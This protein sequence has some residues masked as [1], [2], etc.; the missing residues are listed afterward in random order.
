V[1]QNGHLSLWQD[2]SGLGNN[3]FQTNVSFQPTLSQNSISGLPAVHFSGGQRMSLPGFMNGASA[4]EMFVVLRIDPYTSG[5]IRG[6]M[7]IGSDVNNAHYPIT[8]GVIADNFGST[9]RKDAAGTPEQDLSQYHIYNAVSGSAEWTS[10]INTKLFYTTSSNVVG[11]STSPQIG[12][13]QSYYFAGDMAEILVYNRQLSDLERDAVVAYLASRYPD[14]A[15]LP[16]VPTGLRAVSVSATQASVTWTFPL[17]TNAP[18]EFNLERKTAQ[19]NYV[20]VASLT[21]ATSYF[22]AG[23]D[24]NEIYTYRV[25]AINFT[26]ISGFSTEATEV[27][28]PA[29]TEAEMPFDGIRV[30]LKADASGAN[31]IREW[32]DQTG[33]G[34]DAIQYVGSKQPLYVAASLDGRPGIHF[35]GGQFVI[36][37]NFMQGALAGE[38]FAVVRADPYTTGTIRGFM[39]IGSNVDNAHYP[40][41]GGVIADNFGSTARKDGA[42]APVQDLSQ[43][44]LYDAVSA[45]NDWKSRINGMLYYAVNSNTVGFSTTPQIGLSQS[46]YFAGDLAE[47]LIYDHVLTEEERLA[48]GHY[49]AGKYPDLAGPAPARPEDFVADLVSS[50]Q[51]YLGWSYTL[52]NY[53]TT[54]VV[55]KSESGGPF[56]EVARVRNQ[57]SFLDGGLQPDTEYSYRVHALNEGGESDYSDPASILAKGDAGPEVPLSN[58]RLWLAA[59]SITTNPVR[60]WVSSGSVGTDVLALQVDPTHRP[61]LVADALHGR[62]SVHFDGTKSLSLPGFM[63]G[64]TGGEMFVVLRCDPY[65]SGTIR[66]FMRVGSDGN[67]AHYPISGEIADSFGS[68]IRQDG[69]GIVLQDLSQ[70]HIYNAVSVPGGWTNRI[71]GILNYT[72]AVNTVG[73][74]N[75]P[76]IGLSQGYYFA[77]DIAEMIVYDRGLNADEEAAVQK[78]LSVKYTILDPDND[79]LEGDEELAIGT[80]P[81]N[82]DSNDNGLADGPEYFAGYDPTNQDTDGDGVSNSEEL[83]LGTDPFLADTDHDGV[84]DGDDAFPVDPTRWDPPGSGDPN[85]HTPPTITLVEPAGATLLP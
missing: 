49:L 1:D 33:N 53:N 46:Y 12:C 31:F 67:N 81:N 29:Q 5:T 52:P 80:D 23:L 42:G 65:T 50:T 85:D 27:Y 48:V 51:A 14:I 16:S 3:A 39:R 57:T 26:G 4:G 24:P 54:F 7:R 45:P 17:T 20:T 37:P 34:E 38:M 6:F 74:S 10:R 83:T 9:V 40:I 82:G 64:A 79:G 61:S 15:P 44:L 21:D 63:S 77:G 71:N 58:I 76:Q 22:D 59:D 78:Y 28:L 47:I 36:L 73:W 2:Q 56:A 19:T 11:F 30:W 75:V 43:Y 41:S 60:S 70:F 69:S 13:S 25:Q 68:T 18:T 72:T 55:E 32:P 62:P 66:G 84:P 35:S 8:G